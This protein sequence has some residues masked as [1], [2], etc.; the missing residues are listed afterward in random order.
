MIKFLL[1]NGADP[2]KKSKKN[3]DCFKLI[4]KHSNKEEVNAILKNTK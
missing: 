3:R 1:Q 2:R 4:E